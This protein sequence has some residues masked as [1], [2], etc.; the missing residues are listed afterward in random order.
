MHIR[1]GD[2]RVVCLL[3]Q[4]PVFLI[5]VKIEA[6]SEPSSHPIDR[7][8][9]ESVL[10]QCFGKRLAVQSAECSQIFGGD[11]IAVMDNPVRSRE[12]AGENGGQALIGGIPTRKA[13][14]KLDA[15]LG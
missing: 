2:D 7:E 3:P 12:P 15:F 11:L 8:C 9:V 4:I 1:K 10:S 13:V 6:A 14:F 5:A